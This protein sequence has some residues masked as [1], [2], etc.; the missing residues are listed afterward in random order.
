M[1]SNVH[2][3]TQQPQLRSS[4]PQIILIPSNVHKLYSTTLNH[5]LFISN[6][7]NIL[8]CVQLHFT[9]SNHILF[10]LNWPPIHS[11]MHEFTQLKSTFNC[12]NYAFKHYKHSN[13]HC[14]PPNVHLFTYNAPISKPPSTNQCPKCAPMHL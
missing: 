3:C 6:E 2:N 1:P 13:Q 9:T 5:A 4:S 8:K 7:F 12:I 10:Q 11:N 14:Q